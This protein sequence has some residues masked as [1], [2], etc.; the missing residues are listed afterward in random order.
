MRRGMRLLWHSVRAHPA[1]F[2]VALLGATLFAVMAVG[3]TIVLGEVTDRVIVPGFEEGVSRGTVLLGASA[4]LGVAALRA[5]GVVMRRY[6][7]NMATRRLQRMWFQRIADRYVSVPLPWLQARSTG[8]LLAHADAD[9]ERASLIMQPLPM[10]FG[11]VVIVLF[12]TVSLALV[13]PV[14]CA[15]ALTLFPTLAGL[16][17]IYS[18]R[19]EAPAAA[20]QAAVGDVSTVAHESFDGALVVKTLGRE[21]NEVARLCETAEELRRNRLHVGRLRAAFEPALDA[22]PNLGAIALLALGSWRM[23]EGRMSAGELVQAIALF[24]ILVFP[25]RVL[26]FLFEELPRAVVAHDRIAGMLAQADAAA[27]VHGNRPLAD[28]GL[29]VECHDL[30]HGY[31]HELVLDGVSFRIE[32]GEVVALVG[33]TGSGKTTLC[34]LI[35]G[36]LPP[37]SGAVMLGDIPVPDASIDALRSAVGLVFQESFLFAASVRDNLVLDADLDEAEVRWALA[38]ARAEGFVD[39][40]PHGLDERIGERGV[41]LSGGQRQRLALARALLRKPQVLLLDD[42][43]SAV[44]AV[45]EQ[46]ILARLRSALVTTTLIVAH[47]VSTIALADRVLLLEGG[48]I[49]AIGTHNE[50]LASVPSYEA[51]VRAYERE[52]AA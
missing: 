16:S 5:V 43:T 49:A 38:V 33:V 32:P 42:A 35:A 8:E 25:M 21:E 48:R 28:G 34:H 31:T 50:L 4:I 40:L 47:R 39:R 14:I 46:E 20:A 29:T 45:V 41:T 51:L 1:P 19:V 9:T 7:G 52:E 26:G 37:T 30:R 22:L 36:L 24:G 18:R 13:D 2:A 3:G 23:S 17:Q 6:F 27:P 11:V 12:A 10:S 44:D 15:I